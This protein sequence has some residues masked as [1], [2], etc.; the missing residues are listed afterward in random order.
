MIGRNVH[1][2]AA[3]LLE[4]RGAPENFVTSDCGG[5]IPILHSKIL[6]W[7]WDRISVGFAKLNYPG[8]TYLFQCRIQ[9]HGWEDRGVQTQFSE[10][11]QENLNRDI[12]KRTLGSAVLGTAFLCRCRPKQLHG[13]QWLRER[14]TTSVRKN[15]LI[16]RRPSRR[17]SPY[18][19]LHR[20]DIFKS[21]WSIYI[22]FSL[23]YRP[24]DQFVMVP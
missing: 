20:P 5:P 1:E 11:V 10:K 8:L 21:I 12:V 3:G 17:T 15:G 4:V 18:L 16:Y 19:G 6:F 24:V 22:D 14:P 23:I 7:S 13:F 2:P 9:F